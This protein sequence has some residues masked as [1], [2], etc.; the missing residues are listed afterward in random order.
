MSRY[1]VEQDGLFLGSSS[2][3]NLVAVVKFAKHMPKGS[4]IATILCD[5]GSRH[6]SKFHNVGF[7]VYRCCLFLRFLL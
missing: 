2:A 4:T 1:L 7:G 5:S 3:V 6:Y